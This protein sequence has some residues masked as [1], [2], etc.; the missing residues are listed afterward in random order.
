VK[1]LQDIPAGVARITGRNRPRAWCSGSCRS[2][3]LEDARILAGKLRDAAEARPR[4][5][6]ERAAG[7]RACTLP[8][9]VCP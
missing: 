8:A 7:S 2:F 3:S 6:A 9:A 4:R 5:V 1:E